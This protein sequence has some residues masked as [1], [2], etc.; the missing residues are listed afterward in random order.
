MMMP[1][2]V[3]MYLKF[4]N[5]TCNGF[6]PLVNAGVHMVMYAYYALSALGPHMAKHLWWKRY[7]TQLQLIQF[8][9]VFI[10]GSYFLLKT[11]CS[12]PKVLHLFQTL[13]A[14]LFIKLFGSF[15]LRTYRKQKTAKLS[16]PTPSS[17]DDK[18]H[19]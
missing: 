1:I 8:V 18:K 10:H 15:Y 11:D 3:Y 19:Q 5:Y 12:C 14:V 16:V 13:H 17:L 7:I 2:S 4:G 9:L 6:T